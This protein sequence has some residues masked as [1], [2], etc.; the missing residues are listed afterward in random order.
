[1]AEDESLHQPH[2]KLFKAGFGDP[3]TAAGFLSTQIPARLSAAIAWD[4]LRPEKGSFV[5]SHYRHSESDLLFSAD[6]HGRSCRLYL[7]F[8]HQRSRDPVIVPVVL[9]HSA[10]KWEMHPQFSTLLDIPREAEEEAM[11]YVPD[12]AF[13]LIE[14]AEMPVEEMVGT[15]AG[16][17]VLRAFR[18][19]LLQELM[20]DALWDEG[21]IAQVPASVY[22]MVLRYILASGEIDKR[23]F[24]HRVESIQDKEIQQTTM[25]LA[26]QFRE[27]GRQEGLILARQ[28]VV[29]EA[30]ETRFERV[31][32]G[33]REEITR[34][35]DSERLHALLRA[36]I[37]CSS[38]EAFAK[39]L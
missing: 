2:D 23:E 25:T 39:E 14:L 20:G 38:V 4:Q 35:T 9:A 24:T 26:Q 30:L 5:D 21:L 11:K 22:E 34:I 8:E 33:L 31:P 6:L 36:A 18:A 17:L 16:I 19:E 10:G 37:C 28:R 7:L 27:E 15:P 3:A 12:F 13:R 29:E 32:E 1:M